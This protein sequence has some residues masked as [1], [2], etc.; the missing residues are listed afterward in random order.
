MPHDDMSNVAGRSDSGRARARPAL[1]GARLGLRKTGANGMEEGAG[2]MSV[3]Q[4][5]SSAIPLT[6]CVTTICRTSPAAQI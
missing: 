4:L 5:V 1:R 6:K 2:E 3:I